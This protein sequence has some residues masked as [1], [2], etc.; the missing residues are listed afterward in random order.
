[1]AA[2]K[3]TTNPPA[4]VSR[5]EPPESGD[6]RSR[7]Q[8]AT[9]ERL[10][11]SAMKLFAERGFFETTVEDIT[12]A[13][14]LGKGTFFNYFPSK[15]HVLGV[16][17]EIQLA[18][19]EKALGIAREQTSREGLR[20]LYHALPAEAGSSPKM[21]RSMLTVFLTSEAVREFLTAGLAR[22]R[23]RL[24][25]MFEDAQR[26]DEVP[27]H[28]NP[29]DLAFRFQQS[30]FGSMLLW[31]LQTPT[32]PL[33]G[34]LDSGFDFFWSAVTAPTLVAGTGKGIDL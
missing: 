33:E 31:T 21:V 29:E 10:F 13:A 17:G 25:V 16:L 30:L 12:E 1:M 4:P 7:R 18:K 19:Y 26:R 3:S 14:D 6:R 5:V 24:V 8:T 15:E 32:P 22:A 27:R 2:N 11:R 28:S 23:G 20:W 9:R 34:W